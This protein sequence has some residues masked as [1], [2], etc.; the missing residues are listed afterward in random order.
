MAKSGISTN[1]EM[2]FMANYSVHLFGDWRSVLFDDSG[3]FS[4][5]VFSE[6]VYRNRNDRHRNV[7][8]TME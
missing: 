3:D 7:G 1:D 4:C 8:K 6:I 2:V 5:I